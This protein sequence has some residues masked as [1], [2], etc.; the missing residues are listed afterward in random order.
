M[1]WAGFCVSGTLD[2]KFVSSRM[3]SEE[4]QQTL[5]TSLVPFLGRNKHINWKYQQD[6]ASIHRS[7]STMKWFATKKINCM[8]W[9][10]LSPDLNPMENLWGI[11]VQ[12]IYGGGTQYDSAD[13][14]KSAILR[15]WSKIP[16]STLKKLV[17][18]MPNRIADVIENRG[19]K[20]KY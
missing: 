16:V 14:L 13:F 10:A 8:D 18:S 3:N 11:L 19:D 6:N 9:P 15:A 7:K 1:V 2:L 12:Q 5:E 20:T 4:Y 17:Q